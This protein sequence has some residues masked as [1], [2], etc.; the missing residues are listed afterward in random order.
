MLRE[1]GHPTCCNFVQIALIRW[2]YDTVYTLTKSIF[3]ISFHKF[4][5]EIHGVDNLH[6]HTPY[7]SNCKLLGV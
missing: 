2:N 1:I 5:V 6:Y 4:Q 3:Y 7:L